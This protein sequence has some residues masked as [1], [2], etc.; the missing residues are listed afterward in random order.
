MTVF[1]YKNY[2]K[3]LQDWF[4][5]MPKRGYGQ[6]AKLAQAMEVNPAIIT[7]V[8]KGEKDFTQEQ[9]S[10]FCDYVGF[11]DLESDYFLL[12]V[13]LARAS[14]RGLKHKLERQINE[15]LS[16]TKDAKER[17][18][19]AHAELSEEAK[20]IFYSQW[21][22]SGIRMLTSIKE[23]QTIEAIAEKTQL[24][25]A[26]VKRVVDFLLLQNLCIEKNDKILMG[27]QSTHI[28]KNSPLVSRHHINWR[29]RACE[30][31]EAN[32]SDELFFTSPLSIATSDIAKVQSIL[33]ESIDKIFA[34]VNPSKE[35]EV[36]CLNI[37]WFRY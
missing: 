26:T 30:Q 12:M 23:F 16:K 29:L 28:S 6:A 17:L 5:N 33:H 25:R 1:E 10:D 34:V 37:D 2:H 22:F 7:Q 35:E 11:T 27:P 32:R 14:S 36:A 8:F 13:Q 3:F 15:V 9:A 4:E 31:V 20:S 24:P 21:Y 18:P 19:N